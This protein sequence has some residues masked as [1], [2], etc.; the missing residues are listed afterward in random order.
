[1]AFK[2]SPAA[3]ILIASVVL[4]SFA[5][6]AFM[7]WRTAPPSDASREAGFVAS[8]S[9]E[10]R[11]VPELASGGA[12]HAADTGR[13]TGTL[14][15]DMPTSAPILR[16]CSVAVVSELGRGIPDAQVSVYEG[17]LHLSTLITDYDGVGTVETPHAIRV[18]TFV[19]RAV[20]Y[21]QEIHVLNVEESDAET[22]ESETGVAITLSSASEITGRVRL[23][24]SA[25]GLPGITVLAFPTGLGAA[26]PREVV[27]VG[28]EI[29]ARARSAVTGPDGTFAI[30]G[31]C[32]TS[33]YRVTAGG[34]G[35]GSE[36][37]GMRAQ[38]ALGNAQNL[39]IEV[40]KY[41]GSKVRLRDIRGDAIDV[42]PGVPRPLM[43]IRHTPNCAGAARR[44]I[45]EAVCLAA[46][47]GDVAEL[48]KN[49]LL[50]V[51]FT[52]DPS[53]LI[54]NTTVDVRVP[55]YAPA[56]TVVP[57]ITLASSPVPVSDV[58]LVPSGALGTVRV[59]TEG[60][61]PQG[62]L[63]FRKSGDPMGSFTVQFEDSERELVITEVPVG[64]YRWR[65]SARRSRLEIPSGPDEY[66]QVYVT[67]SHPVDLRI[68]CPPTGS[69]EISPVYGQNRSPLTQI[70][71]AMT[72]RPLVTMDGRVML[73][74]V[75]NLV[76]S[77]PPFV[78]RGLPFGSYHL[79]IEQPGRWDPKIAGPV[80]ISAERPYGIFEFH[81]RP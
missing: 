54:T 51:A 34:L 62:N 65:Y 75:F 7:G 61:L 20:G 30:D 55:G 79:H 3:A 10:F 76:V 31:L 66:H 45:T 39:D 2:R 24:G 36:L 78:I 60:I 37:S 57:M 18:L 67:E 71:V 64:E 26:E 38:V 25:H 28:S 48:D 68:E 32:G 13:T 56:T 70:T 49:E 73:Q 42:R 17:A 63:E 4:M 23:A 29:H 33:S 43:T 16:R 1:M 44:G 72:A 5:V 8:A 50:L 27:D 12:R 40:V 69:L 58:E 14:G 41:F 53:S 35:F 77:G 6:G 80:V 74:D 46:G 15:T 19:A 21:A 81:P 47:N 9:P 52:A 59:R 22:Q 11:M